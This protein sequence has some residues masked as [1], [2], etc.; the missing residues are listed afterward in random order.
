MAYK[1]VIF[2]A[3]GKLGD[4]NVSTKQFSVSSIKQRMKEA[5]KSLRTRFRN[6]IKDYSRLVKQEKDLDS[7]KTEFSKD[8]VL[9][10]SEATEGSSKG[11]TINRALGLTS[12]IPSTRLVSNKINMIARKATKSFEQKGYIPPQIQLKFNDLLKE[13]IIDITEK[14]FG[15][16]VSE[17]VIDEQDEQDIEDVEVNATK[18]FSS[19]RITLFSNDVDINDILEN[20]DLDDDN[21]DDITAGKVMIASNSIP[22]VFSGRYFGFSKRIKCFSS[23]MTCISLKLGQGDP[24]ELAANAISELKRRG[25][26]KSD[27]DEFNYD[28]DVD[29]IE[30]GYKLTIYLNSNE[31]Q[32]INDPDVYVGKSLPE[33]SNEFNKVIPENSE[34]YTE[35]FS[36][37]DEGIN[38][39]NLL[40]LEK[41]IKKYDPDKLRLAII[42]KYGSNLISNLL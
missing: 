24:E 19:T 12:L 22:K 8:L 4:V 9:Y 7:L 39:R 14:V 33:D 30:G 1:T 18:K 10:L 20:E 40:A 27:S 15:G 29:Q 16:Q 41:I 25:V 42:N 3:S 21:V 23:E 35:V 6:F 13:L 28:I 38:T 36:L 5:K 32:D 26:I 34:D 37:I 2:S 17:D 31:L 11:L